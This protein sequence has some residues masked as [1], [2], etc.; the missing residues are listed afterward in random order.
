MHYSIIFAS[1]A[2][3]AAANSH[4][5]GESRNDNRDGRLGSWKYE[6][7]CVTDARTKYE[8]ERATRLCC[9]ELDGR[10]VGNKQG[11][12]ISNIAINATNMSQVPS[13][14]LPRCPK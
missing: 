10:L 7:E 3:L 4:V 14:R 8:E 5:L 6:V 12:C 2:A 9:D 1:L 11:V 13:P